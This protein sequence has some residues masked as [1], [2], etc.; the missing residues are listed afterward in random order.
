M[1]Q[2]DVIESKAGSVTRAGTWSPIT[3]DS[4]SLQSTR[5]IDYCSTHMWVD[6]WA[7][8]PVSVVCN[9]GWIRGGSVNGLFRLR[10]VGILD[11]RIKSW[12]Y[13]S[14]GYAVAPAD[15]IRVRCGS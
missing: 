3:G 9:H 7:V 10:G 5:G 4:F 15:S 8:A 13:Q 1:F 11:V 6:D 2:G 14:R 12:G